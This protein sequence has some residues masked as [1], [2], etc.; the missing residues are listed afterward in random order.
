[1]VMSLD[2]AG[3]VRWLPP[4]LAIDRQCFSPPWDAAAFAEE[5]AP[6][7]V[8]ILLQDDEL[9]AYCVSR[10]MY[11]EVHVLRI[12]TD[13]ARRRRGHAAALLLHVLDRARAGCMRAV[14]LEVRRANTD[15]VALYQRC[16]FAQIGLRRGYYGDREDAL[17]LEALIH[18]RL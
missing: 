15:A 1:M 11:D 6:G 2:A 14:L 16:G 4:I 8:D 12:A 13:P 7:A 9:V 3:L 17:V 10:R 5:I 18:G